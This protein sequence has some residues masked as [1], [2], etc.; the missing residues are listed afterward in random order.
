MLCRRLRLRLSLAHE[1]P[2]KSEIKTAEDTV[3]AATVTTTSTLPT[4]TLISAAAATNP[5]ESLVGVDL[6]SLWQ[7]S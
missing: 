7:L 4:A 6:S 3:A 1:T 2:F 5:G